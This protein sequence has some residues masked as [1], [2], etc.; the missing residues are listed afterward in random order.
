MKLTVQLK[1]KF[2][3]LM[4]LTVL[5]MMLVTLFSTLA[6]AHSVSGQEIL[7]REVTINVESAKIKQVLREIEKQTNARF[8]YSGSS[9]R[10]DKMISL[11][12]SNTRLEVVLN[13]MLK[14][15]KINYEVFDTRILLKKSAADFGAIIK[16]DI[17]IEEVGP[18]KQTVRGT[19]T[20]EQNQPLPGVNVLVKSAQ[21]GTV[22]DAEGRY[23]LEVPD[24]TAVLL[25]S[26]IGFETQEITVG[27]QAVINI[28]LKAAT[29]VL[30]ELVVIGYGERSRKDLTGAVSSVGE[31]DIQKSIS[32]SPEL[33]MQG[34]MAG[35]FVS[36][37][38]GL[39][40][41]RPNVQIRGLNTFGNAQPLYVVDGI[42]ITEFNRGYEK[43]ADRDSDLQGTINVLSL[44][45]P[46]D[47]ESISVLK[48]ASSAAI[49]GVRA[50]N[51][52]VLITTKKGIQGR[53]RLE[54]NASTGIQNL[55]KTFDVLDVQQYVALYQETYAND[56]SQA[57]KLPAE[58]DPTNAGY[59]GNRP[60]V[61]WQKPFL[62]EDAAIHDVSAKISGG[63]EGT[64]YYVSGGYAYTEAPVINNNLKRYSLA[65]NVNSRISKMVKA[66]VTYRLGYV[67]ANEA[68]EDFS[69]GLGYVSR[70]S[71]W[72]QIYDINSPSGYAPSWDITFKENK[73]YDPS[74]I[75]SGAKFDID[76]QTAL[77][78]AETNTNVYAIQ[79]LRDNRF[80]I[81]RNLGTA[82]A[83]IEPLPGLRIKGTLSADWYQQQR[84]QWT[85]IN[86]YLY[87]QTPGNPYAGND[88]TSKG[89]YSERY[90]RN[91]NIVQELSVNYAKT[92]GRH[93]FDILLN[94]ME[95]T[96]RFHY[97][98]ANTSQVVSAD[99]L[100]RENIDLI[101]PY[102]TSEANRRDKNVLQ[103]Y[104]GRLSY[105]FSDKYYI[106]LTIRRDGSSRFAPGYKW[107]TFPA[108]AVAWRI[109]AEPFLQKTKWINDLK[110]RAGYGE[111][112][113]QETASFAY[114]SKVEYKPS[115]AYGSGDNNPFGTPIYG[116]R[117]AD[118]PNRELSWEVTKTLNFAVDGLLFNEH[119]NFTL[120]YYNKLTEGILQSTQLP[121]SVGNENNPIFNVA[122]VRNTGWELSLGYNNTIGRDFNF[123]VSGNITTVNNEVE[124]LYKDQSFGG[125]LARIESGQSLFYL[126][127][128]QVGGIFQNQGEIDAYVAKTQD[129]INGNKFAPGDIYFK[130]SNGDG[131]VDPDDR[132]YLGRTIPGFYY[133][134]NL[135]ANYKFVD[136]SIFFQGIGDI[137]KYNSVRAS[138]ECM[139]GP[140]SNMWTSTLDRWTTSNPSTTMPR[141]VQSDPAG[142]NRFSSR[143]VENASFL[144]LKNVQVG[145]NIPKNWLEATRT[146]EQARIY[147]SGTNLF[148]ATDWKGLDPENDVLP[149]AR[150]WIIGANLTF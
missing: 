8:V 16:I 72:Q 33:A 73:D 45:S 11:K 93:R 124:T 122:S 128:Y 106:D 141:A 76:K 37:P 27:N 91:S 130:D 150:T 121:S 3:Q 26:Y 129:K 25:F 95:Q 56:P 137:Y 21:D 81:L 103:G 132:T 75:S 143:F 144:R 119:V 15:L 9:I 46:S 98:G 139:C 92:I 60:T 53:S 40:G 118:F 22:T 38:G 85:D 110:L 10:S 4:R 90:T 88:G 109:S 36:T 71:P 115:Y 65:A 13:E 97:I 123:N 17:P 48:D 99:P 44:I 145:F 43:N 86:S 131:V 114:L 147:V 117:L 140:G 108:A 96:Y 126:W 107:G 68:N 135:G 57:G 112:G 70:T 54:L 87:N 136:V 39:P 80:N 79:A 63:N 5:Q 67:D 14:P 7:N 62:N 2:W 23:E 69:G 29:Q 100:L 111:L 84:K 6:N 74:K 134:L 104:L 113:N 34:R 83:Q 138:G 55:P 28:T 51:G 133:G 77:W 52:V 30:D 61:D 146:F 42:P 127:G 18:P 49:Y 12:A 59:L 35:V 148:T 89:S 120:E 20:D 66:G 31:K 24:G 102:A 116:V 149:P 105:V 82:Y 50:A 1:P 101:V 78:G 125:E 32:V 47:I 41:A 58:F 64:N 19:V 142:N 94:A